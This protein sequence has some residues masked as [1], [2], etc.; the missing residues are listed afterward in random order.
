MKT[1]KPRGDHYVAQ[2]Y[3]RHFVGPNGM[4]R[5]YRKSDLATFPCWPRDVCKEPDGDTIPDFLSEPGFLG[6]FRADFE[7]RWSHAVK[8]LAERRFGPQDKL[9]VAGYWANLLVCTPTWRRLGIAFHDWFTI[10]YLDA[11]DTLSTRIGKNDPVLRDGVQMLRDGRL[12]L[13]TEPGYVRAHNAIQVT[14]HMWRL[15]NA[16][17]HVLVNATDTAYVTSDNPA[18]FL[19]QG[20]LVNGS[21]PFIRYLPVTPAICLRCDL[22]E[23]RA[24][25]DEEP[26]FE[27]RPRGE[28]RGGNVTPDTVRRV[29]VCTAKCAESLIFTDAENDGV[30]RLATKYAGFRVEGSF[31]RIPTSNG[32]YL[33]SQ[34]RAVDRREHTSP[35]GT[36]TGLTG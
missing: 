8:G 19:D 21:I 12:T 11:R 23:G 9:T 7:P 16:N 24:D 34:T 14:K 31:F 5:A 17:W 4:L 3:L 35:L 15:Y 18:S 2:T 1:P 36:N 6:E 33:G 27:L 29:N 22:T 13:N 26:D 30:R 10:S 32:Y 25:P 28:I 20:N